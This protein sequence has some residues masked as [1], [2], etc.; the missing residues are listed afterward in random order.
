MSTRLTIS[1]TS[2]RTGPWSETQIFSTAEDALADLKTTFGHV[3]G[4]S[5]VDFLEDLRKAGLAIT[6]EDDHELPDV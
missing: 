2:L 5:D 4:Q 6:L 1:A 3:V